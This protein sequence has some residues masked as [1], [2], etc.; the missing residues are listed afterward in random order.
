[1]NLGSFMP[2]AAAPVQGVPGRVSA[3]AT[4]YVNQSAGG[5]VSTSTEGSPALFLL[6]IVGGALLLLHHGR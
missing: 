6:L 2:Q 3:Q 5:S 1:M 4:G